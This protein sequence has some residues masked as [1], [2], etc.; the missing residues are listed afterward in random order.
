MAYG[1]GLKGTLVAVLN[2]IKELKAY[3]TNSLNWYFAAIERTESD[4][5]LLWNEY[6][7]FKTKPIGLTTKL[8]EINN[9]FQ[10]LKS[11]LDHFRANAIIIEKRLDDLDKQ[12]YAIINNNDDPIN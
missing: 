1:V 12:E 5:Q 6:F 4:I 8:A 9:S 3:Y 11:A 7:L 2:D 10:I